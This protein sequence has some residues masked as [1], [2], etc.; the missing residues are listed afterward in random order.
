MAR[1]MN[2]ADTCK[3]MPERKKKLPF[4]SLVGTSLHLSS[5]EKLAF[6]YVVSEP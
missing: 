2:P 4:L 3:R 5:V 1:S 6:D